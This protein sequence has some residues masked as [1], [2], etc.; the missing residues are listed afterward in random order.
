VKA[1]V[2]FIASGPA[3]GA[4]TAIRV[5][6]PKGVTG[7]PPKQRTLQ[8]GVSSEDRLRRRHRPPLR[9]DLPERLHGRARSTTG[10]GW[11][12][13]SRPAGRSMDRRLSRASQPPPV[14]ERAHDRS[15]KPDRLRRQEDQWQDSGGSYAHARP[16]ER[17]GRIGSALANGC[18]VAVAMHG[19]LAAGA[20]RWRRGQ[21]IRR[22]G[23]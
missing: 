5:K 15:C 14:L 11:G 18:G 10:Y 16:H 3:N 22:T 8:T 21:N 12:S 4:A 19:P 9:P 23:V 6:S 7:P 2:R 17:S 1:T 20:L 13:T